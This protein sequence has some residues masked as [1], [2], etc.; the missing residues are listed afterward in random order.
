MHTLDIMNDQTQNKG[1][2]Y[3]IPNVL[4]ENT[5]EQ[6][7]TPQVREVLEK[8]DYLLVENI[9]TARR[10]ISS[11]KLGKPIGSY[12]FEVADKELTLETAMELMKPIIQGRDGG[13][14][15]EAGC[16]GIADPG[17]LLV[18]LAHQH[19]IRVV[20][21]SGPSSIFLA[22]MASGFNGQRFVFHGYLPIDKHARGLQ[23]KLLEKNALRFDETQIFMETPYRNNQL[24]QELIQHCQS[25][26]R[27][28]IAKSLTGKNEWIRTKNIGEWKNALPDLHKEPC[29]FL[30]YN[31]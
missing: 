6:V 12:H 26:T 9:R 20:P 4:Y 1:T 2:L 15:S 16:P 30:L 21:I 22:L 13:I 3:L 18:K 17:S 28:C 24:M 31:N 14:I 23:I 29:M 7:I 11:L 8:V 27:L 5:Q 10:F 25:T 19:D